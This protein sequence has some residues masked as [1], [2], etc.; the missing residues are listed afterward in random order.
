MFYPLAHYP[1][2]PRKSLP[3][4]AAVCSHPTAR[5]EC[6][7]AQS[8]SKF[9]GR[10]HLHSLSPRIR[11]HPVACVPRLSSL[12]SLLSV[13]PRQVQ[14]RFSLSSHLSLNLTANPY[15]DQLSYLD[16]L[17]LV[18]FCCFQVLHCKVL[19]LSTLLRAPFILQLRQLSYSK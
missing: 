3:A 6:T 16:Q 5:R 2:P 10:L 1:Y 15:L 14:S 17:L 13:I 19:P 18:V 4:S 7:F 11:S 12:R 9:R 8:P